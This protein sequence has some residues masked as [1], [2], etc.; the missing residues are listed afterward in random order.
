MS[1]K[2]LWIVIVLLAVFLFLCWKGTKSPVIPAE[3]G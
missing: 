1:T 3:G 2:S